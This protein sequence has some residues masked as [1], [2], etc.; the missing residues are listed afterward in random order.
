MEG[1]AFLISR[2][3]LLVKPLRRRRQ[4]LVF[5][6]NA[7]RSRQELHFLPIAR[8]RLNRPEGGRGSAVLS[9]QLRQQFVD[10]D[11]EA[12]EPHAGRVPDCIRHRAGAAR[13]A[14]L[15]DALDAQRVDVRIVLLD[16]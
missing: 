14:D 1:V 10:P 3:A 16:G 2:V 12:A 6:H 4:K 11:W 13:D 5:L 7:G 9:L 8:I 15:A